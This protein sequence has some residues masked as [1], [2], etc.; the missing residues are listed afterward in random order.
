MKFARLYA[1][2]VLFAIGGW[3]L[4]DI[5]W[6]AVAGVFLFVWGNN[7]VYS[8]NLLYKTRSTVEAWKR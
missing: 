5:N 7:L 1:A 6:R 4:W 3:L 8:W 2:A